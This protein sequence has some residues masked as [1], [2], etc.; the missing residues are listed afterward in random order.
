[1]AKVL[2]WFRI[3]WNHSVSSLVVVKEE[4]GDTLEWD[5]TAT[6]PCRICI[7]RTRKVVCE[8]SLR[9]RRGAR[10]TCCN[11]RASRAS[12]RAVWA[13]WVNNHWARLRVWLHR[14]SRSRRAWKA[15]TGCGFTTAALDDSLWG[16]GCSST[17]ADSD[18]ATGNSTGAGW[19]RG[20]S[21]CPRSR[22]LSS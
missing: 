12:S 19:W 15:L 11:R 1:M 7:A 2:C 9:S 3:S 6:N 21:S 22:S 10:A 18:D 20:T 5:E 4:G 16:C 8:T 17:E 14:S 13:A